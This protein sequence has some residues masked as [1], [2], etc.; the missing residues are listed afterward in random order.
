MVV[1]GDHDLPVVD[2]VIILHW[3]AHHHL[4]LVLGCLVVDGGRW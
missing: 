1:V 2:V 4:Q 3:L